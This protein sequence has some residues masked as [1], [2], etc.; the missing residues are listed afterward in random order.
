MGTAFAFLLFRLVCG[1]AG[2][3]FG[4]G[5]EWVEAWG[6]GDGSPICLKVMVLQGQFWN[7][8]A[9]DLVGLCLGERKQRGGG[10]REGEGKGK[11]GMMGNG[12]FLVFWRGG[13]LLGGVSVPGNARSL[14]RQVLTISRLVSVV[15]A[16]GCARTVGRSWRCVGGAWR[17]GRGARC[18]WKAWRRL[19]HERL[20]EIKGEWG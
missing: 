6:P 4:V 19:E 15:S 1:P 12:N 8:A 11:L 20:E 10:G 13:R 18:V 16:A 7:C 3:G 17:R 9:S 2:T 14:L 5:G